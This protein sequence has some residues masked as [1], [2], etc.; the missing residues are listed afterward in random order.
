MIIMGKRVQIFG[1]FSSS[2]SSSSFHPGTAAVHL[3]GPEEP[4][5]HVPASAH[6]CGHGGS[7]ML[8]THGPT[9]L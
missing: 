4:R 6:P 9:I 3:P 2:S 7:R 5:P 8:D 1:K